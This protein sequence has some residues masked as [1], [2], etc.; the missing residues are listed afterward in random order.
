MAKGPLVGLHRAAIA[1]AALSVVLI[2]GTSVTAAVVQARDGGTSGGV[3]GTLT[4]G[5]G[6]NGFDYSDWQV[7]KG[8]Q[9]SS[10][11]EA[12]YRVPGD[13]ETQSARDPVQYTAP[14]GGV[15]AKGHSTSFYY[16]NDCVD[17][18][19]RISAAWAALAD[20]DTSKAAGDALVATA[21]KAVRAW[22]RGYST[23]V[24]GTTAPMT[25]IPPES[26]ELPDGTAAGRARME[27]DMTVFSGPCLPET[28][29]IMVTSIETVDGVKSLVQARYLLDEGGL[30]DREWDALADSLVAAAN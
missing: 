26:V 10:G 8:V 25:A 21:Q 2:L 1:L 16:G 17:A 29:E 9:G 28:A 13:W 18:G 30:P 12:A 11:D 4:R 23:N 15:L 5:G 19:A 22:G 24:E 20:P 7:V 6:Q 27:V 14:D 3:S